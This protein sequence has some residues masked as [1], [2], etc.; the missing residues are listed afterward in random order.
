MAV[1]LTLNEVYHKQEKEPSNED[2]LVAMKDLPSFSKQYRVNKNS[3]VAKNLGESDLFELS[4]IKESY[5]F[6]LAHW[7]Q[8]IEDLGKF[9]EQGYRHRDLKPENMMLKDGEI[10]FIDHDSAGKYGEFVIRA[11]TLNMNSINPNCE[12]LSDND[13]IL[14][15]RAEQQQFFHIMIGTK[16]GVP[17]YEI[18]S[19]EI[20]LLKQCYDTFVNDCINDNHQQ[21]IS[22]FLKDPTNVDIG[23]MRKDLFK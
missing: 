12:L 7:Y 19:Y 6:D 11:G 5:E 8:A 20:D 3:V 17:S 14:S 10:Y 13:A 22:Q 15:L 4:L 23:H 1:K 21:L 16:Y 2:A 9:H 18:T